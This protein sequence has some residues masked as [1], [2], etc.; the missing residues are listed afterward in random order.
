MLK[1]MKIFAAIGMTLFFQLYSATIYAADADKKS[2]WYHVEILVLENLDKSGL[3][4]SWPLNPGHP[5]FSQA[6]RIPTSDKPESE[7]SSNFSALP[8]NA[9]ILEDAKARIQKQG[10]FRVVMHKAWRQQIL[11]KKLAEKLR[12]VGGKY[13]SQKSDR[14]G[15]GIS[16]EDSDNNGDDPIGAFADVSGSAYE[17]DGTLLLSKGRF[18]HADADLVFTKPMRVLSPVAGVEGS[19]STR[20]PTVSLAN[21]ANRNHWT[22]ETNARLQPFRLTQDIRLKTSEVQYIDHPMYGI[23]LTV[24]PANDG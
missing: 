4:E 16:M 20:M 1:S 12:L 9:Y 17:V 14:T 19:L 21:V 22:S 2:D 5:N 13:Y 6:Q 15:E 18:L 10:G 8:E 3:Q 11:D 24:T 7:G 23:L